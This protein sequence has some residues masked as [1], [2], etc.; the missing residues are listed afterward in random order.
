MVPFGSLEDLTVKEKHARLLLAYVD[1]RTG[2]RTY[3]LEEVAL[4]SGL[5][6]GANEVK[7]LLVRLRKTNGGLGV[8]KKLGRG[9]SS[10]EDLIGAFVTMVNVSI[11]E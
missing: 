3:T 5:A 6:G 8:N 7:E 2:K 11:T 4:R 10:V 1:A 9:F